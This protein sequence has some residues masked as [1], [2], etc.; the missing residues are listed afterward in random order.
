MTQ[1]DRDESIERLLDNIDEMLEAGNTGNADAEVLEHHYA[2]A[3][4]ESIP[5]GRIRRL[6]Q[7][8]GSDFGGPFVGS[9][10]VTLILDAKQ[11][12]LV[13]PLLFQAMTE[14]TDRWKFE[15]D[16]FIDDPGEPSDKQLVEVRLTR[17]LDMKRG[18]FVRSRK[19]GSPAYVDAITNDGMLNLL[20]EEGDGWTDPASD[21]EPTTEVFWRIDF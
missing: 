21:W 8:Y 15:A 3:T 13:A 17:V 6:L 5:I 20:N 9:D 2:T 18:I 19:D 10:P 7:Q 14:W 12:A 16:R 4:G 1:E 11:F